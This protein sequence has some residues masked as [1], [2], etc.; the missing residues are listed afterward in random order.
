M[1][2]TSTAKC[3]TGLGLTTD[4]LPLDSLCSTAHAAGSAPGDSGTPILFWRNGQPI[5]AGLVSDGSNLTTRYVRYP[6]YYL[7]LT[8]R[9]RVSPKQRRHAP[10]LYSPPFVQTRITI[11]NKINDLYL[12]DFIDYFI[13]I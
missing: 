8:G 13:S 12:I 1:T 10:S 11:H 3:A 2:A 4:K 6:L 5:S 7:A 9:Q